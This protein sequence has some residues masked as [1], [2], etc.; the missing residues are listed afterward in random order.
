MGSGWQVPSNGKKNQKAVG[1]T[2]GDSSR[3]RRNP[4]ERAPRPV[5]SRIEQEEKEVR[6]QEFREDRQREARP[7]RDATRWSEPH[8]L[9][10][11]L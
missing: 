9:S 8:A 5:G 6:N 10:A 7:G 3:S 1:P 2:G 11:L 4:L